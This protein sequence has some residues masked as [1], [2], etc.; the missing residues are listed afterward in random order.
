MAQELKGL[1][2][3]KKNVIKNKKYDENKPFAF[4]SY[5]HDDHD[6]QIVMNI[7]KKMF[8]KGYNL[9]IDVANIP[10]N[11]AS[12][13]TAARTALRSK[14]CKCAIF[15]RSENSM[16][17]DTILNEIK[18]I[19]D[20]EHIN[21][22][23][24]VDIWES[25]KYDDAETVYKAIINQ[26]DEELKF[27]ETQINTC[28]DLC[29]IIKVDNSA[30]RLR[31]EAENDIDKAVAEIIEEIKY[32]I[33]SDGSEPVTNTTDDN[34]S[35]TVK[36][37][38]NDIEPNPLDV[39]KGITKPP[40]PP[41]PPEPTGEVYY[42]VEP[43]NG[44]G[45]R[46]II[47]YDGTDY[48]LLK[49][50]KVSNDISKVPRNQTL[51]DNY[52][53]YSKVFAERIRLV[54][55]DIKSSISALCKMVYG[56]SVS[57]DDGCKKEISKE[58]AEKILRENAK[59]A[60]PEPTVVPIP[61]N[62]GNDEDEVDDDWDYTDEDED[63]EDD[64][65]TYDGEDEDGI[66]EDDWDY[67][68]EDEDEDVVEPTGTPPTSEKIVDLKSNIKTG[69]TIYKFTLYGVTYINSSLK[70]MVITVFETVLNRNPDKLDI[71]LEKL[72][73]NLRKGDIIGKVGQIIDGR[74]VTA[75][76]GAGE[77]FDVA[78]TTVSIGTRIDAKTASRILVRL[79]EACDVKKG[80][81]LSIKEV[82]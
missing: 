33:K 27:S 54:D 3:L 81:D 75:N 41:K 56:T 65:L 76:F 57:G 29:E 18:L 67:T 16:V 32:E 71:A 19:N 10:K 79:C 28:M 8:D 35:E 48:F 26:T 51:C 62:G 34:H 66:Y 2:Y 12:W 7:F 64:D 14:L 49:K 30:I 45:G 73:S 31:Y 77:A 52:N 40:K 70:D 46:A 20:L 36:I 22:F 11:E 72:K 6:S 15:F 21:G 43:N 50:S 63:E 78:G 82:K 58:E 60:V 24:V 53:N 23:I 68:D 5:S 55:K 37:N 39:K 13:K 4:I 42:L 9:W 74:P 44:N 80:T 38:I 17:K 61:E 25:K 59:L 69:N 1:E 47:K